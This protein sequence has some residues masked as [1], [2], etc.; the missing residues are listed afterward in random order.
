MAND[1]LKVNVKSLQV[2]RLQG[3][4]AVGAPTS[5]SGS[6]WMGE[7]TAI[8]KSVTAPRLSGPTGPIK[9][10]SAKMRKP[11]MRKRGMIK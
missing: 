10:V 9:N 5:S 1:S 7:S 11:G 4:K 8:P 2:P 6:N 3:A